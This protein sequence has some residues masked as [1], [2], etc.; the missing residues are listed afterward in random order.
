[1]SMNISGVSGAGMQ[2]N[3]SG[4]GAGA[5]DQMDP[6]SKDLR[7]QIEDLQKQMQELS[8]NQE[9]PMETKMKKRQEL[10]KQISELEIQLRQHQMEVKREENQKKKNN[11]SSFDDLLGTKPQEKQ[12]GKQSMGMSAGSMEALISAD[13]SMKQADVHGRTATKMENRAGVLETEIKLDS[14]RGG[15]S[16]IE[17]KEEELAKTKSLADQATASQMESLSQANKT[18][19]EAAKDEQNDKDAKT[20]AG[21]KP[22]SSQSIA[23]VEGKEQ[24][25]PGTAQSAASALTREDGQGG[26]QQEAEAQNT[27]DTEMMGVAFSRGYQ[28]VDV[29]L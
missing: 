22:G 4:M 17:F 10:Q 15:S 19:Q 26:R 7:R 6:V 16:N 20:E 3:M 29:K 27:F 1:M 13:A 2:P 11:G 21:A 12:G 25:T 8:A 9:M 5:A 23:V 28:P 18:M 14:G 24:S